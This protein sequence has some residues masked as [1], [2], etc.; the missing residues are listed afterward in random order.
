MTREQKRLVQVSF[1]QIKPIADTVASLFY[2]SLFDLD[3]GLEDLFVGD[4]EEQ[5]R[6]LMQ[7]LGLAVEGLDRLDRL[8]PTLLALGSR[9]AAYGI[10]EHDYK[11]VQR[12]LLWTLERA[13]GAAF[14]P[15]VKAAWLA[16][17]E[18]LSNTVKAGARKAI[19][20]AVSEP[21]HRYV[22]AW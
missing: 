8:V 10:D 1:Q 9:H 2:S 12:A 15:G 20:V 16:V 17:Y 5:G 18:L 21:D 7:L 19:L 3:P 14:T 13:L 4:S 22:N 6:K 11:A